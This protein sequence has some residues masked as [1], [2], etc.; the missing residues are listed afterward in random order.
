MHKRAFARRENLP[1][2]AGSQ[3]YGQLGPVLKSEWIR[4]A[5]AAGWKARLGKDG[6]LHLKC[7]RQGCKGRVALPLANLGPVPA[8]CALPHVQQYGQQTYDLY[9]SMVDELKRRRMLLGLSQED[10]NAA[11]G[12]ADGH[13]NKLEAFHRTAQFPTLKLWTETL[14]LSITLTPCA[15][16]SEI[17]KILEEPL[18]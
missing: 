11:A 1:Y 18:S 17:P 7:G 13:I 16:P 5:K 6:L 15:L 12:L 9:R 14:G 3:L 4:A 8:P 10:V 2:I